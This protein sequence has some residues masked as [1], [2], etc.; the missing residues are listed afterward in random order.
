MAP[1][2]YVVFDDAHSSSCLGATEVVEDMVIRRDGLNCEQIWPH[3]VFR[4]WPTATSSATQPEGTS[5][6]DLMSQLVKIRR[7]ELELSSATQRATVIKQQRDQLLG[8]LEAARQ[9]LGQASAQIAQA[10]VTIAE[11]DRAHDLLKQQVG[12]ARTSRW[13][14]LGRLFGIGPQF[15]VPER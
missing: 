2:G 6:T 10:E 4:V 13:V 8:E 1:G 3:F 11:L 12:M 7:L 5:D 15:D 14:R 9:R